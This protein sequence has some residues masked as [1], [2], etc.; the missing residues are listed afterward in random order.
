MLSCP[1]LPPPSSTSLLSSRHCHL[2]ESPRDRHLRTA[3]PRCCHTRC[4]PPTAPASTTGDPTLRYVNK[5]SCSPSTS[6]GGALTHK[7]PSLCCA[8]PSLCVAVLDSLLFAPSP[9]ASKSEGPSAVL[10]FHHVLL[11]QPAA[12]AH[13]TSRVL[14]HPA[15]ALL[16]EPLLTPTQA[17]APTPTNTANMPPAGSGSSR[18]I[19]F[20]VSEQ[21]D[22]QDVVG[23]GA[24]GVVWYESPPRSPCT[25]TY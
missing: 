25:S 20:N 8:W 19:S 13:D 21:Y 16:P 11:P 6:S 1:Q 5:S 17:K 24:Y 7:G 4:A 23:E 12:L 9:A 3:G 18:K 2:V 22:I 14:P 10:L 15:P